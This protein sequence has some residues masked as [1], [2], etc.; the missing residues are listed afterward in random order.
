MIQGGDPNSKGTNKASH[1]T[2]GPGYTI[3]AEIKLKHKRGAVATARLGDEGNPRKESSGSQ[4]FICVAD[5]SFLDGEYT[6]FGNVIEGMEVADQIVK[7][8]RDRNDNPNDRIEMQVSV[9]AAK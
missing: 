5:S 2:G 7:Q 3:P 4:F 1:G 9:D 8:A 6:V